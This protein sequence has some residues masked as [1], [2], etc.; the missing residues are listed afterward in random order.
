MMIN[1]AMALADHGITGFRFD[2][3][4]NGE[5]EGSFNS[6]FTSEVDD[7]RS[8]VKYF[9]E[10]KRTTIAVIGHSKGAKVALLYASKYHD[11]H[12]VVSISS[13]YDNVAAVEK[14]VGKDFRERIEN[15]GYIEMVQKNGSYRISQEA[16]KELLDV[17]MDE[18]GPS[19]D[20][21][22][23]VLTVHGS[24]DEANPVEDAYKFP[25]V[26][27]N[28]R[29]EIIQGADHNYSSHQNQLVSVVLSFIKEVVQAAS[30]ASL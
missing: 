17:K 22:C 28:H 15:D 8:V 16:L 9:T 30:D 10:A 14:W 18:I 13:L 1:I 24:A 23:K 5:S 26:I 7:V 29:L 21:K 11:I 19:I 4:G 12:A 27:A 25:N 6:T 2:F 20:N 3:S